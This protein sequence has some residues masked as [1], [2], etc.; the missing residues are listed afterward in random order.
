M[1]IV[2]A[3][4]VT[5]RAVIG[6]PSVL[7]CCYTMAD[8]SLNELLVAEFKE[9]FDQFDKVGGEHSFIVPVSSRHWICRMGV[10]PSQT[11][12]CSG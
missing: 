4:L 11:R 5:C 1:F 12:S 3:V 9:A 8:A 10:A 6:S 7:L 2:T